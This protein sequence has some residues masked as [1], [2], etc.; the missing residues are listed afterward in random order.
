MA[1]SE[2]LSHLI[3]NWATAPEPV[4]VEWSVSGQ[5]QQAKHAYIHNTLNLGD[6]SG[7]GSV[8]GYVNSLVI[9]NMNLSASKPRQG[10]G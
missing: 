6:Y 2:L 7:R 10:Q 8:F 5:H 3:I 9:L 4:P 1:I